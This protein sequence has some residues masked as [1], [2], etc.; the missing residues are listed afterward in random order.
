MK[1]EISEDQHKKINEWLKDVHQEVI[2]MQRKSMDP[3]E[4]SLLTMDGKYPYYGAIGGGLTYSFMLTSLGITTVVKESITG[5]ELNVT[6]YSG[7]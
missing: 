1:F 3:K 4:F 7:W 6:D 2:E 5:K